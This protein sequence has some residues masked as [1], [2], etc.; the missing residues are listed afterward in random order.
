MLGAN[1]SHLRL[2]A[3]MWG[4]LEPSRAIWGLLGPSGAIWGDLRPSEPSGTI[5]GHLRPSEAIWSHL[6]LSG[7]IWAHPRLS[8]N[9]VTTTCRSALPVGSSFS[10]IAHWFLLFCIVKR[11]A[12][13][14]SGWLRCFE[15]NTWGRQILFDHVNSDVFNCYSI[16]AC[17]S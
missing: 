11:K 10:L 1:W 5:R 6:R 4:H 12:R 8:G 9:A 15:F 16:E 7:A 13:R 17:K 2:S 14:L 3:A